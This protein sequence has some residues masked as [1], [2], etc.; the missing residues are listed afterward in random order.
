MSS[1]SRLLYIHQNELYHNAHKRV[2]ED[3][4]AVYK[5]NKIAVGLPKGVKSRYAISGLPN[6]YAVIGMMWGD[7]GKGRIVDNLLEKLLTNPGIKNAYVVR[8]QGGSNAGHT[9]Y[10][11]RHKIPLHQ[12]PSGI[13]HSRS[14]NIMD[15]AMVIHMEDLQTEI[16]DAE[17]I[18][19]DLQERLVLSEDAMLSTDLE[20]AEEVFLREKTLGKS[21]G[22]TGRGMSQTVAHY[23]DRQGFIVA[24]LFEKNWKARFSKKYDTYKRDF[25]A[26]DHDLATTDVPDFRQTRKQ[27]K[28]LTRKVGTKKEFLERLHNVRNWFLKRDSKLSK[29]QRLIQNTFPIHH[30]IED[31]LVSRKA[32]VV[33]E[34]AQAVGLHFRLGRRPDVTSTDTTMTGIKDSTAYYTRE[35]IGDGIGVFK[36]TYDSSVGQVKPMTIIN[37][38]KDDLLL[39]VK[40]KIGDTWK[41]WNDEDYWREIKKLKSL[42]VEQKYAAWIREVAKEK[43]TTT[44]RY[45]EICYLDLAAMRFNAK[46][47]EVTMLAVTHLDIARKDHA[48]RVCTH[49]TDS[50][51]RNSPY[52]P[53]QKRQ[54]GL[55]PHYVDL[56][57]FDGR[58]VQKAKR[59]DE[60]PENAKKFLAF[61][62]RQVGLPI[63]IVSTGPNREDVVFIS[64]FLS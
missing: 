15:S 58:Q 62:Q 42:S 21:K 27:K 32:S 8:F 63:T 33:F 23:I 64:S 35:M 53:G 2:S 26:W 20:R 44:G 52:Q 28:P 57:G 56:P 30:Q 49:Y 12:L 4:Q 18:V 16:I 1:Y 19:G 46:M 10:K 59:F 37:L 61:I 31:F 41:N 60:L 9:V 47:S 7:E 25:A 43:G 40:Q 13:L 24:D 54:K 50:K 29:K 3:I 38:P 34:G 48:I 36:A 14:V 6:S 22:G 51:G 39:K 11:D 45:R 5:R 55:K 17:A